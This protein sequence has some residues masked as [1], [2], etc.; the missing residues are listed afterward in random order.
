MGRVNIKAVMLYQ[1]SLAIVILLGACASANPRL[2]QLRTESAY[3]YPPVLYTYD[4]TTRPSDNFSQLFD[5]KLQGKF[6]EHSLMVANATGIL[7]GLRELQTDPPETVYLKRQK[8][9]TK[10]FL[11]STEIASI[12]AELDCEG[13]R[14]N[15]VADFLSQKETNRVRILTILSV[16]TG[17]L[18]GIGNATLRVHSAAVAS[19]VTGGSISAGLGLGALFS[20]RRVLFNH[21]RNLLADIWSAGKNST[22]YPPPV[23]YMLSQKYFSNSQQA[24]VAANMK[25]RWI[26]FEDL[27]PKAKK[28]GRLIKLLFGTGGLY[29]A[30]EL[31]SRA[32]MLNQVQAAV[33]LMNQDL[34]GLIEDISK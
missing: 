23:W 16:T 11:V 14:A 22:I 18:A 13:E 24:P 20:T 32:R 15:Q 8:M 21:P 19:A 2:K 29:N 17:A 6:S 30:D 33:K 10:L 31:R 9:L 7:S 25:Q 4:S 3:C 12:A 27:D 26:K 5:D 1:L 34:Q 28:S